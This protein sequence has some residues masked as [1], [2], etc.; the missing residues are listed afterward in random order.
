[1]MK[2]LVIL[3]VMKLH[4]KINVFTFTLFKEIHGQAEKAI[5]TKIYQFYLQL[6]LLTSTYQ[7]P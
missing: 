6:F 4:A 1:M 7:N 2:L 3:F 5:F